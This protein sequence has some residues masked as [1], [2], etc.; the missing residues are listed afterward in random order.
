MDISIV[1][2]SY[3]VREYIISCIE[4]IYKHSKSN[5]SFELIIVDNDSKDGTVNTLKNKFP[6]I[7][8]ISNKYNAGFSIAANQGAQKCSGKYLLIL[9]PDTLFVED[10]LKKLFTS[11]ESCYQLGAIGPTLIT[12]NG[13]QQ[14]SF[15]RKP[16][17]LS[18]LRSLFY[19]D[20]L[21]TKKNYH[22]SKP[23]DKFEVE[24]ISGAAFLTPRKVF[25][26]MSGL[27]E[28]LF[29]MED[30]DYCCRLLK[31]KYSVFFLPSTKIIH[32]VGKS[33]E[34]NYR[35]AISNQLISK[36]KF[37]K[38][39]HKK[40]EVYVVFLSVLILSIVKFLMLL[41]ISPLSNT[42]KNKAFAYAFTI[43]SIFKK[44][45]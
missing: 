26:K 25:K 4:S 27:N 14:Q 41:V 23:I 37:F 12:M 32:H 20:W 13:D 39:H 44:H 7:N 17:L 18:T 43:L 34:K 38:I 28:D 6:K 35:I 22:Y 5:I 11:A 15:W 33:S 10:S 16:N 40:P 24:T 8:I 3:N 19:L 2:V 30:I 9:N 29:W 31:F 45:N 36:I 1:I 21:N 42:F